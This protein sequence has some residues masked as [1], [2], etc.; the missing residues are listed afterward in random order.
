MSR[1][2]KRTAPEIRARGW[3]VSPITVR[4]DTL[5]PEPDSPTMPSAWPRSTVYETPSTAFTRPSSVSKWT[6]RSRTTSS[7]SGI[8]DPRV[9]DRVQHVDDQ[10]GE[11]DEERADQHRALDHRQVA[12]LDRVVCEPADARNVEHGL[13]EDRAAEQHADVDAG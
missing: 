1:P 9:D 11:D 4:L 10:V 6:F 13:G 8:S 5:L 2:S 12:V 7:G 3:R